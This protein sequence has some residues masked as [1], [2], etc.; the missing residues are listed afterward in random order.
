MSKVIV[1]LDGMAYGKMIELVNLLR[2][3]VWGF[4]VNDALVEHGAGII[5]Q[6]KSCGAA[7]VMADPKL[8]DIPNTV[9]N[10]VKVLVEYGADFVTVH[11]LAGPEVLKAAVEATAGT[12]TKILAISVLT[13]DNQDHR[14]LEVRKR[15]YVAQS[16]LVPGL[17][18]AAPDLEKIKDISMFKVVPGIRPTGSVKGE[19]QVHISSMIPP[20]ADYVVVG[21]PITQAEDPLAVVKALEG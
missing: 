11:A 5:G 20:L 8:F 1:A 4:K 21:R 16:C 3:K 15:A 10:S 19:D 17:V 6:L 18:C 2:D 14:D 13:S 12:S 9:S 7:H